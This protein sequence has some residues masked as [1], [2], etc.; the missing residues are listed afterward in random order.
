MHFAIH[1]GPEF[2]RALVFLIGTVLTCGLIIAGHTPATALIIGL[3]A[4]VLVLG[5]GR[6][7]VGGP[8]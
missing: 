7:A 3:A 4:S 6:R 2:V 8:R 1:A 5:T